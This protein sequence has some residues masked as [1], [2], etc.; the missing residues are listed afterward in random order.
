VKQRMGPDAEAETSLR[1][2]IELNPNFAPAFVVL[3]AH[4]AIDDERLAEALALDR[5]RPRREWHVAQPRPCSRAHGSTGRGARSYGEREQRSVKTSLPQLC[6]TRGARQ[7]CETRIGLVDM[8]PALRAP[9]ESSGSLVQHQLGGAALR[10][11]LPIFRR[12]KS[13]P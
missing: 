12:M 7:D 8:V 3:R 4:L 1:R 2:A 13:G 5:A 10:L 11:L 6:R 9:M